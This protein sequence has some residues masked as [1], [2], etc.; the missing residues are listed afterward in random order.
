MLVKAAG[1]CQISSMFVHDTPDISPTG[2]THHLLTHTQLRL[3][4]QPKCACFQTVRGKLHIER[5][6][7][8]LLW[9]TNNH[10]TTVLLCANKGF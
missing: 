4:N 9:V 10:C 7:T 2:H 3:S 5:P 8:L 1:T 6:R